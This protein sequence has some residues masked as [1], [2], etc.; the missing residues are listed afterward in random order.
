M[1]SGLRGSGWFRC[2]KRLVQL[3]YNLHMESGG[4][5]SESASVG[6]TGRNARTELENAQLKEEVAQLRAL[7]PALS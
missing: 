3:L 7:E 1:K 4:T 2:H 6:G 5:T